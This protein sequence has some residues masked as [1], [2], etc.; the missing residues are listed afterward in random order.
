MECKDSEVNM[1]MRIILTLMSRLNRLALYPKTNLRPSLDEDRRQTPTVGA[2]SAALRFGAVLLQ[3]NIGIMRAD[4]LNLQTGLL[5]H[6]NLASY[7]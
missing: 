6:C 5:A 7:L 2:K 1:A 3:C 4:R